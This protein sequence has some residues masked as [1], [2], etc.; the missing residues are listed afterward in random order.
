[1]TELH[2]KG[3]EFVYNHHLTV[4]HR[5]LVPHP[6]KG[7]GAA[8]L[9]GNLIIQ[10]DNLH[11]LKAL[12]PTHAG[13]VDCIFIDPPYNTGNEGWCY[14]DNVNSPMI[15]EWLAGNPI[16][17][18]DGLRHDKWC[19]MMW[20]RLR[21]LWE[22]LSE[23][24]SL[25]VTLDENEVHHATAILDGIFG[26]DNRLGVLVWEKSDSPRMD[27]NT[28][29]SSHD[30]LLAYAKD[31]DKILFK[32]L[33]TDPDD[34]PDHYNQIDEH[35]RRFY[36]KPLRAM[37]SGDDTRAARPSLYF[38][39]TAPDGTVVFPMRP[40]GFE[41]RWRW[42]EEKVQRELSRIEWRGG[43]GS[44]SPYFRIYADTSDGRPPETIWYHRDVGS[45]RTA[46]AQI[47]QI[48]GEAAFDTPKPLDLVK[49]VLE[50]ATTDA[51]IILDSFAGSG[52]T[53]HAVLEANRRDGG[54]RRFILVEMEDYADRLTAERVRR[55]IKGY[56][57]KGTQKTELHRESLT[58]A[59]LQKADRFTETVEKIETLHGHEYT[60]I[61]KRID[62]GDFIVTGERMVEERAAGLGGEFT[63]CT[64]G[65]PI[66]M[67]RIL[68]GGQLPPFADLGTVLFHTATSQT[69]DPAQMNAE[70]GYLGEAAGQKLWLIYRADLEWL[71]SPAAALTLSFAQQI[72]A[73]DPVSRHIVFAP[74][75]HTSPNLLRHHRIGNVEFAPLPYA[76]YRV[77]RG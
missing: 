73:D 77:E 6:D 61:T 13:K 18:E 21:L 42:G 34:T 27:A 33:A 26:A 10:G 59:K 22:L 24:G 66:D 51:S 40:D 65:D 49:R 20:P 2:F 62:G 29:S 19:A 56:P 16:G 14:N 41:G 76:L 69:C 54:N 44:W 39:L 45:S 55:V 30:F 48:F 64:L 68:T 1:M 74:A 12:L 23:E 17:I 43:S 71:K 15:K 5:P 38:G 60:K 3:K 35:S 37:G 25:W 53:A 4:P 75:N 11:A 7:V 52:T 70:T 63:Y 67:D 32:R 57:F 8:R 58:W 28:F 36:L 46:K 31:P 9:D 50:I 47:K 72:S